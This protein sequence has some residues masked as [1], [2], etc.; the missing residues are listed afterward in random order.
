MNGQRHRLAA[1]VDRQMPGSW[2]GVLCALLVVGTM[3]ASVSSCQQ[4]SSTPG[5]EQRITIVAT[6]GMIADIGRHVAGEH[7]EVKQLMGAGVD[8]HLYTPTRSDVVQLNDADIVFYNGLMLEGKMTDVFVRLARD[9]KPVQAVTE[10]IEDD[11]V[12]T[13]EENLYDPHVWMDVAGWIRAVRAVADSL[14]EF[15]SPNATIYQTNAEKYI[16]ELQALDDYAR[17]SIQS[18]PEPQRVLVTAHDAFGYF[19][20]AYDIEVR[21]IQGLST[22]SEAG[23][24]DLNQLIDFLVQRNIKAVFVETSVTDDNVRSLIEGAQSRGHEV[25]IGGTLFSDAMGQPG[26]YQ[27]TYIGMIDHNV[28]TITR[29]L[30][31]DAPRSGMN[32][33]L[34]IKTQ[35]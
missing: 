30:G 3:L 22:S 2:P 14:A 33:K 12:I 9:G 31:G 25:T 13:D 1:A 23:L 29:A 21:G 5:S 4:A 6:T 7:A 18:I 8:P 16:T 32:G 17:A 34:T 10:L 24:K 20:R 27:G 28:T 35:K 11:F 15:D 26:T 19:G